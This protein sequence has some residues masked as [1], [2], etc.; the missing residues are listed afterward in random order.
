MDTLQPPILFKLQHS[1]R[2]VENPSERPGFSI[3]MRFP[4]LIDDSN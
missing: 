1:L 3:S 2:K 4:G